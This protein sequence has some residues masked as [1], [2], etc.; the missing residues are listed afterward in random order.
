[1]LNTYP[2]IMHIR[3]AVEP[4]E[5]ITAAEA[6]ARRDARQNK[7]RP[8][9]PIVLRTRPPAVLHEY[10]F[11]PFW[12]HSKEFGP[13]WCP[14]FKVPD[15]WFASANIGGVI[16]APA[17]DWIVIK[18]GLTCDRILSAVAT[19]YGVATFELLSHRR[20]AQ[21]VKPRHIA[22]YLCKE[23][24]GRSLP[25]IGQRMSGRDHT[26]IMHGVRKIARLVEAGDPEITSDVWELRR[27]LGV[28]E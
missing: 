13:P 14:Q 16:P 7:G 21:I 15:F 23:L 26:T 22:M 25:F 17:R 1:M 5:V 8:A 2:S 6:L 9:T 20:S 24:T 11:G 4:M 27:R 10:K 18:N 19:Y 28:P 12:M 3:R